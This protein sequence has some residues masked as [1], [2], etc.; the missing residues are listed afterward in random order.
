[1]VGTEKYVEGGKLIEG[2]LCFC[3]AYLYSFLPQCHLSHLVTGGEKTKEEQRVLVAR[4]QFY[5]IMLSYTAVADQQCP[6]RGI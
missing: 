2:K 6:L 3:K 4:T 5:R 1:M